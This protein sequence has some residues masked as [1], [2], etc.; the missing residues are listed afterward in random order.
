M[1]EWVDLL[2]SAGTVSNLPSPEE[3]VLYRYY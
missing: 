1:P 3:K 2:N